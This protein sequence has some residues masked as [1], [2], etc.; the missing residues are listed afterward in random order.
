MSSATASEAPPNV[1][2]ETRVEPVAGAPGRYRADVSETWAAP[3]FPSGGVLGAVALRAMQA[4][5]DQP[6]QSLRT[7]STMFVSTVKAG[8]LEIAVELLRGGRRMSQLRAD[9]RNPGAEAFGHLTTAAFGESREGF[10]F[11]QS[12]APEVGP[13]DDYPGLAD[14]PPGVP[15]FRASF[16]EQLETRRVRMFHSF[17]TGWQGGHAEAIRWVRWRVPPRLPDGKLDPFSLVAIADTMPS[18]VGQYLGPGSPF[19]HCPSVDLTM[20]FFAD[21]ESDW[22]LVRSVGHWAGDG[23]ASAGITLWDSERRL[24]AHAVQV[25]LIRFPEPSELGLR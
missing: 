11:S 16:F 15:V 17:E 22:L 2:E 4:E 13:P 18:A 25:M 1:L 6:H 9:L 7:F 5:L 19:F 23:Y 3:L 20:H 24:L 21:T 12:V 8:P 14:P 10:A